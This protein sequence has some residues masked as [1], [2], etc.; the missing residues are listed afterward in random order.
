MVKVGKYNILEVLKEVDFGI[1]FDGGEAGEILMPKQYVP[2]GTKPGDELYVFIYLDSEDRI[3]ATTLNPYVTVGSFAYL[4]VLHVDKVGAFLDWGLPKD[5]FV[6]FRE[7]KLNM[8]AGEWHVVYVYHDEKTNRIVASAKIDKFISKDEPD[9]EVNN[10]VDLLIYQRTD[11]GYKAIIN[12]TYTGLLYDSELVNPIKV[13]DRM[14]GYIKQIRPDFKID[15]A[16]RKQVGSDGMGE[17]ADLI[18]EKI[19]S[20]GGF[21][22]IGDKSSAED[23]YTIFGLSKKAFKKALGNLYRQRKI[24]IDNDGVRSVVED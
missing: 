4:Q 12:N 24:T 21:M 13:G 11:L 14:T 15:L 3:I 23:I 19:N 7:Q 8:Q 2:E 16:L 1:Y 5:L 17:V 20:N 18:L 22:A 9:L 6:P 10:E